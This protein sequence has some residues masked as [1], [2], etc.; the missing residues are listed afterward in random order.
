MKP[1]NVLS[2]S[3]F[4]SA[5][6]DRMWN[7]AVGLYL[8]K[9]T[10]GSLRLAA[11]YGLVLSS[12]AVLFAPVIGD[13]IDRKRRLTV[14]RITLFLQNI[15]VITC[16]LF[17]LLLLY[18]VTNNS[19]LL[20]LLQ[21]VVIII[22]SAANLAGQG[23]KISVIKDW[24]VVICQGNNDLL[25]TTNALFRRIDLSV[26]ILAPVAVGFLMTV[27]SDVS[28]IIFICSWNIVSMIAE[29]A[30]ILHVYKNVPELSVKCAQSHRSKSTDTKNTSVDTD[31]A[32]TGNMAV[33]TKNKHRSSSNDASIDTD[34]AVIGN[35]TVITKNKHRSS[36]N[37]TSIDTDSAVIG[38]MAVITKNKHR[39]SSNDTS[40]DT[41]SA[42]IGNMA[43]ITKN[44]HRSSSNDA[45][46][47]T[48]SAVI[49]NMAVITKNEH[50]SSSNDTSIHADSPV[51]G[52]MAVISKNEHRSS[53]NDTSIHTDSAVIGNM[54]AITKN[55]HRSSSNDT[56]IHTD[57]AGNMAVIT[58][59][60]HR[61]KTKSHFNIWYGFKHILSG[62]VV[63]RRQTVALAGMSLAMLY[64][65]VIG[66]GA[67]TS[68][69]LYTQSVSELYI[70]ICF[71]LGSLFGIAGT[72]LFPL[73]RKR[74]GLTKTGML[75]FSMQMSMLLL[76]V[77]SIWAPGSPS[78]LVGKTNTDNKLW[79]MAFT[80][81][82]ST[83]ANTTIKAVNGTLLFSTMST[84]RF[85]TNTTKSGVK[86]PDERSYVSV[87]LLLAGVILSR[88][89]LWITDLT[90][91]QLQQEN[92]VENERGIVGGVQ[93]SFNC[94]LDLIHFIVTIGLPKQEQF[95]ILILISICAILCGAIIYAVFCFKFLRR[96]HT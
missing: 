56:S 54:A 20:K 52:N 50:R 88:S 48:D 76:C 7:F 94:I 40:I 71:G 25:A 55:E 38:N 14:I 75:G 43:V 41:D 81:L 85:S 36:S 73:I 46:I 31:S 37:D 18:N 33:I 45:S 32:V 59:N 29:Y 87:I 21:A 78:N 77:A 3:S 61:A 90:I 42:V 26:A 72:F 51:I 15:L 22:G 68:G 57:S 66:F 44:K 70:S 6:G 63:Y 53:S 4:F 93:Y 17:I 49:G 13:W 23:E 1:E 62:W 39:S 80:P 8:V 86:E 84:N 91:T 27:I 30:L 92:V 95:G 64:L 74:F 24:V 16:A 67:I 11:I 2:V 19:H 28:G 83:K 47:D 5:W 65:T 9:L 10:P 60:E 58:K 96:S 89:G 35:M 34:S 69:Y 79:S 82:S 12:A